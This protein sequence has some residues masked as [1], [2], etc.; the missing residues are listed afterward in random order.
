MSSNNYVNAAELKEQAEIYMGTT[1]YT[2]AGKYIYGSAEITP[3]FGEMI[4]I[5]VSLGVR[6]LFVREVILILL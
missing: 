4:L 2:S 3:L 5:I 6:M 1:E